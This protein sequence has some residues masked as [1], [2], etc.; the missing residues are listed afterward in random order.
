[1]VEMQYDYLTDAE[2]ERK[3]KL[4]CALVDSRKRET[5]VLKIDIEHMITEVY[6]RVA[7]KTD[8]WRRP[9]ATEVGKL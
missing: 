9:I 4:L 1:M 8:R 7:A 3:I 2:L 6:R 5:E